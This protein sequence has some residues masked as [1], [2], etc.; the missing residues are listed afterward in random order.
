MKDIK[1]EDGEIKS[2]STPRL[3]AKERLYVRSYLSTLSHTKAYETINPGLSKY[4]NDNPYS[5]KESVQFH[6]SSALQDRADSIGLSP[7]TI[8]EKL[9]KEATLY[10]AG[11]NHAARIQALTQLG[12][13]FGLFQDKKETA[14]HTFNIINYGTEGVEP[15]VLVDNVPT[16]LI[17]QEVSLVPEGVVLTDYS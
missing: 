13:H 3:D 1:I 7:D 10:G 5:R 17:E 11:S 2:F 9:Y 15:T 6:I 14:G 16:K 12:K 8:L 4:H